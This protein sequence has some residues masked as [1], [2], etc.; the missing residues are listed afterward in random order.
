MAKSRTNHCDV[1]K[2][3]F[4]IVITS[5][6]ALKASMCRFR[7]VSNEYIFDIN[8]AYRIVPGVD[9]YSGGVYVR[10]RF[11]GRRILEALGA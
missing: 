7:N 11:C 8:T 5:Y 6:T 2:R 10:H 9:G 3:Q 1:A 4:V